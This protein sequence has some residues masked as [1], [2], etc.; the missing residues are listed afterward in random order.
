MT[1]CRSSCRHRAFVAEYAAA[2]LADEDRRETAVGAYGPGSPEWAE[3]EPAS[4]TFKDW[5]INMT[6]WGS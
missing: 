5:L 6:G 2:R 4:V 3:Y 1:S